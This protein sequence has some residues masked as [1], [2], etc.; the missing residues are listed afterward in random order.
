MS[1]KEGSLLVFDVDRICDFLAG[2]GKSNNIET[3]ITETYKTDEKGETKLETRVVREIHKGIS[4]EEAVCRS[5]M[6]QEM[7]ASLDNLDVT[8]E[9]AVSFETVGESLA[10]NTLMNNGF[11]H[12]TTEE[13]IRNGAE[14]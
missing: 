3:E 10:F 9:G 1:K 6:L 8:G 14:D 5:N 13:D 4:T 2:D 12:Y 11:I 7:L